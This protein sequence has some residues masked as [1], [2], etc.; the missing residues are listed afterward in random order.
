M[1]ITISHLSVPDAIARLGPEYV[2]TTFMFDEHPTKS[3]E[4]QESEAGFVQGIDL[5]QAESAMH[6]ETYGWS[7]N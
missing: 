6:Q 5:A 2:C 3:L 4:T 7:P 1:A